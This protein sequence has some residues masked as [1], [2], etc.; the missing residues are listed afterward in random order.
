MHAGYAARGWGVQGVAEGP[1]PQLSRA[2]HFMVPRD[3]IRSIVREVN[4][5]WPIFAWGSSLLPKE[6]LDRLKD[7]WS[8]LRNSNTIPYRKQ[9]MELQDALTK[10][11]DER[12]AS[13]A[14]LEEANQKIIE[15]GEK[16]KFH[17]ELIFENPYLVVKGKK[18]NKIHYCPACWRKDLCAIEIVSVEYCHTVREECPLCKHI[19]DE[20]Y[21]SPI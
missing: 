20:S 18:G 21:L 1:P 11:R 10:L 17:E 9:V 19:Y 16:F 3:R 12:T 15:L 8:V 5:M 6:K 7:A 14:R 4:P 2:I 13:E